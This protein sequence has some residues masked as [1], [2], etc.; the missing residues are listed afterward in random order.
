MAHWGVYSYGS[1]CFASGGDL[2]FG[3]CLFLITKVFL[4]ELVAPGG[5]YSFGS[6][7][8]LP[9]AVKFYCFGSNCFSPPAGESVSV[10][11]YF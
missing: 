9:P 3:F 2:F 8:F 1:I 10:P 4:G 7:L 6:N 11:A 5:V